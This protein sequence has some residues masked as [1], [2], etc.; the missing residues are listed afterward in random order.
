MGPCGPSFRPSFDCQQSVAFA[1]YLSHTYRY[2]YYATLPQSP[3]LADKIFTNSSDNISRIASL[4]LCRLVIRQYRS[5]TQQSATSSSSNNI[6]TASR[7]TSTDCG[8][9]RV[10]HFG[11]RWRERAAEKKKGHTS[12]AL[13]RM[14]F[15]TVLHAFPAP[16]VVCRGGQLNN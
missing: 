13:L 12:S 11:T 14:T 6:I 16:N 9:C 8:G 15:S 2:R 4:S 10:T 5:S 1:F 7:Y 3:S